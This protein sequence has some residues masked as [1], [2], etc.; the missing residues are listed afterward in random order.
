MKIKTEDLGTNALILSVAITAIGALFNNRFCFVVGGSMFSLLV[1]CIIS[2]VIKGSKIIAQ[3]SQEKALRASKNDEFKAELLLRAY[4]DGKIKDE[5][6]SFLVRSLASDVNS[7][8][9]QVNQRPIVTAPIQVIESKPVIE[10]KEI[11]KEDTV[12]EDTVSDNQ[13]ISYTVDSGRFTFKYKGDDMAFGPSDVVRGEYLHK[14]FDDSFGYYK[15][16][17]AVFYIYPTD[18]KIA[19]VEI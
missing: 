11:I 15:N 4:Q 16:A 17:D 18:K 2:L 6:I 13:V 1:L 5:D 3:E 10:A 9:V 8:T 19:V 7:N 12:Q 14:E